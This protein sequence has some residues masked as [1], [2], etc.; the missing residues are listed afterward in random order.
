MM[1][2]KDIKLKKAFTLIEA[3]TV[4]FIFSVIVLT[5]YSVTTLGINYIRESKSRLGAVSLANEK[6]EILRNLDYNSVGIVGG[7]PSGTIPAI[8]DVSAEGRT[9]RVKTFVKYVDDPFDGISPT[10]LDFKVAKITVSWMG[11]KGKTSSVSLT[12]RFVPPG[13]E[14]NV[15]GGGVLSVNI[16]GSNGIGVPQALVRV[17]NSAISPSV[18]VSAMTDDTGNL[19]LPGAKQSIENYYITVTKEGYESVNTIDPSTVTYSVTDTP[20][21]VVGGMMNVKSIVQDKLSDL[22]ISAIDP[23]GVPLPGVSFD[24][25]GG[26]VLGYDLSASPA[27]PQYNMILSNVSVDSEGEK[28]FTDISPGQIFITPSSV[29]AGYTLVNNSYFAEYDSINNTYSIVLS[30]NSKDKEIRLKYAADSTISL[31]ATIKKDSNS[32]LLPD[33]VITLSN[34]SGYSEAITTGKDGKAFFPGTITPLVPG[35]Y[36][37]SVTATGYAEYTEANVTIDKL[38]T[39]EIK[40]LAI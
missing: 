17:T 30:P 15:S 40:M 14:Q 32:T 33:A 16:M 35:V 4:L 10:D 8:E 19:M 5:F 22:K 37:M 2:K 36:N 31:L 9:Y 20:A 24:I 7:I 6:M 11:P 29:P 38:I 25:T 39:K 28:K 12:G 18:D 34:A 21:S 3:V 26:R 23:L 13:M 1:E 27:K